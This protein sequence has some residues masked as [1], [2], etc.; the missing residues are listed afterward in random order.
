VTGS[1]SEE[2]PLFLFNGDFVD[3]GAW[4]V[5]TLTLLLA[6][7]VALPHL[8]YL[9]RGNHESSGCIKLYG[10]QSELFAKYGKADGKV[11]Q[12]RAWRTT[13]NTCDH[14]NDPGGLSV[15]TPPTSRVVQQQHACRNHVL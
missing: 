6:W 7:K 10:F 2:G 13:A 15:M 3:R 5:E 11:R 9:V 12:R 1:P 14:C 8:V 4:G